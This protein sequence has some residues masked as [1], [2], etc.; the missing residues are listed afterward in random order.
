LPVKA[1]PRSLEPWL[2][3]DRRSRSLVYPGRS[4]NSIGCRL[5]PAA[6]DGGLRRSDGAGRMAAATSTGGVFGKL[7]GRVGDSPL[8]GASTWAD[9]EV[10]ISCTGQGE[11]FI[12]TAAAAQIATACALPASLSLQ[13]PKTCERNQGSR[14]FGGF[15]CGRPGGKRHDAAC[16]HGDEM[17]GAAGRRIDRRREHL[18]LQ[19]AVEL[20]AEAQ[21]DGSGA[22]TVTAL[23]PRL[24]FAKSSARMLVK[25]SP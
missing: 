10:A 14:R 1:R 6:W 17:G 3:G 19:P 21:T 8:I 9:R 22:I 4:S 11:F 18:E 16:V 15:D 23:Y 13:R 20:I 12:C 25:F 2:S 5:I 7:P 24:S